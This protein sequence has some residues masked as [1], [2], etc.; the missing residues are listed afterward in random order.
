[1][2]Y[3]LIKPT[4]GSFLCGTPV[5]QGGGG[6][7]GERYVSPYPRGGGFFWEAVSIGSPPRQKAGV[8]D[9]KWMCRVCGRVVGKHNKA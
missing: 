6:R 3:N 7:G 5:P 4:A 2:H 9:E 8:L 1:M